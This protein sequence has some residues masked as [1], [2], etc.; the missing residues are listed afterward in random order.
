MNKLITTAIVCLIGFHSNAQFDL[1]IDPMKFL[2]ALIGPVESDRPGQCMNARTAGIMAI[3][4]QTGYQYGQEKYN[5]IDQDSWHF[6]PTTLRFSLTAK[7]ELN[8]SF[9]YNRFTSTNSFWTWTASGFTSPD[10]GV[11][12]SFLK[13]SG[14]KPTMGLQVNASPPSHKGDYQQQNWGTS[15]ILATSNRWDKISVN[16]NF[17]MRF[18]GDDSGAPD[19]PWVF[20]IGFPLGEKFGCFVEG[21]GEFDNAIVSADAGF[22]YVPINDLQI[23]IFGGLTNLT[24]TQK[25][26]FA[27]IG[28]SYR[29]SFLKILAKKKMGEMDM[30]K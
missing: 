14:W 6:V 24:V 8:T 11:R 26:W 16:T 17:S 28:V 12:Y 21:F 19:Y 25:R 30:F 4:I 9:N 2:D 1:E 10:I 18:N 5:A 15:V 13:G 29:F 27:E 3:Q 22:T 7:W 20:N 23:D